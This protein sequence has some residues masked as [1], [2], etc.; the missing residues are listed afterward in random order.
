MRAA[1]LLAFLVIA[2]PAAADE[3]ELYLGGEVGIDAAWLRH[4]LM[5][6]DAP[7]LFDRQTALA[8]VPYGSIG[9][10]Y[11]VTNEVHV[12]VALVGGGSSLVVNNEV[13]VAGVRGDL[14]TG[15]Y[16]E[17][18][19]PM[20]LVWRIES[21]STFAAVFGVDVG[22]ELALW[23]ATVFVDPAKRDASGRPIRLPIDVADASNAG[24]QTRLQLAFDARVLGAIGVRFG[25]SAAAAWV[26]SAS[27]RVGIFLEPSWVVPAGPP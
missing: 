24:L 27:L 18:A 9:A 2:A 11:G 15:R 13:V 21:G 7:S 5:G 1:A 20:S 25:V 23:T 12:G 3:G 4:P 14:I 26:G 19:A 6:G 16:F 10:S 8:L 17:L 22:P